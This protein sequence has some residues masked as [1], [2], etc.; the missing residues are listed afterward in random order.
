MIKKNLKIYYKL[1]VQKLFKFIYGK[2]LISKKSEKFLKK[3]KI[4]NTNFK[5]F[6][7][8]NY[9]L[10]NI[11]KT[12]IYT[13]NNQNVAI[14]K[15][16]F[17]L[18]NVSFQQVNGELKNI[19]YNSVIKKGTPSFIKKIKG[20]VLNLCQGASGNNYFH[21][22][23]DIIPKI[24]LVSSKINIKKID[25]FY[26]AD[27]KNWQIKILKTLGINKNKLLNSKKYN[28][29]FVDEIYTVDHPWYSGGYIHNE[30][31]KIPKW[32]IFSHRK[33]F[34]R[35][36]KRKNKKNKIFLDRSSSIYNH[37]Q[38]KN[39]DEIFNLVRKNNFKIYNPEFLSF[40][41]QISLFNNSSVIIGAHGASLANII[42]CKPKTKVLEI[43][44]AD[45]PNRK[46]ERICDILDLKYFRIIT[47]PDNTDINYP[48]RINLKKE[49]LIKIKKIISID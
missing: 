30:V 36:S 49:N 7:N 8:N 32:I 19:K 15:N 5:T 31:K 40:F 21:F 42:F 35:K 47:D 9:Y 23:F 48:F 29:I 17:L 3:I 44:P 34:L 27:P 4:D 6:K 10:Y 38:I 2:I 46:C 26:I 16:N 45:H 25:H 13:D 39:V 41:N 11:K 28:H 12:R 1:V 33:K 18:P 20:K 14:I 22:M 43:I 24:Y 37:C